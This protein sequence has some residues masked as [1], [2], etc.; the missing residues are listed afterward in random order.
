MSLELAERRPPSTSADGPLV[1]HR[2][3]RI[4]VQV[5]CSPEAIS[6]S[7]SSRTPPRP[8]SS[9][10]S[11]RSSTR[12]G[13]RASK[14]DTRSARRKEQMR[15]VREDT[16]DT[17]LHADRVASSQATR[18]SASTSWPTAPPTPAKRSDSRHSPSCSSRP[19]PGSPYLLEPDLKEGAGGRR[20]FDE[21][22]WTAATLTGRPTIRPLGSR[23]PGTDR[24]PVASLGSN[25]R[26]TRWLQ[27]AG[28]WLPRVRRRR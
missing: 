28:S 22:T 12:C 17:H 10:S 2:A 18:R 19:R 5:P 14:S 13:T 1:A 24:R 16:R 20:D 27:P 4:R 3:G 9:R 26:P 11:R 15:A 25:R 8:R 6:T 7:L 21:L 23:L